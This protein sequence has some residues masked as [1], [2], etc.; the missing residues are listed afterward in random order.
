M[1][2]HA[3]MCIYATSHLLVHN[4]V[5][6]HLYLTQKATIVSV[7]HPQLDKP[8]DGRLAGTKERHCDIKG[9]RGT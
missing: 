2:V 7:R 8:M 5:T 4:Y 1:F 9:S 3:C 6:A